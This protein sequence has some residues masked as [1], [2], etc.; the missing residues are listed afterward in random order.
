MRSK[1]KQPYA[2][3]CGINPPEGDGFEA[4]FTTAVQMREHILYQCPLYYRKPVFVNNS[5]PVYPQYLDELDPFPKIQTF[6][7]NNPWSFTFEEVPE[8]T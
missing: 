2:C 3:P 5:Q 7:L 6:L 8:A 4:G 1:H